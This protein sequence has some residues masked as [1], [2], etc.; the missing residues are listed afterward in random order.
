[1]SSK[2]TI[3]YTEKWHLYTDCFDD[4]AIYLEVDHSPAEVS[5][6]LD[7]TILTVRFPSELWA[8]IRKHP[9][10]GEQPCET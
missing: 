10:P 2:V 4:D 8:A 6:T 1:M 5:F 9:S 3:E 7:P